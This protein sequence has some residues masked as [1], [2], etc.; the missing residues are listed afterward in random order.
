[1]TY[2]SGNQRLSED[3]IIDVLTRLPVKSLVRFRCVCKNWYSLTINSSFIT[4]HLH[5]SRN[6]AHLLVYHFNDSAEKYVLTLFLDETLASFSHL[7]YDL[8]G[9]PCF[10]EPSI[11]GTFNGILGLWNHDRI[12]LWNPAT[13]VFRSL[14]MPNPNLPSYFNVYHSYFGF[15]LDLETNDYKV[16]S[17]RKYW[18]DKNDDPYDPNVVSVYN[19]CTNSWR[20]FQD[21]SPS[22]FV[23]DSILSNTYMNGLYYWLTL[24]ESDQFYAVVSFDM[25]NEVFRYISGPPNLSRMEYGIRVMYFDSIALIYFETHKVEKHF[26][27]WVMEEEGCWTKQLSIGPLLDVEA[28]FG[29]WKN[30]ELFLRISTEELV[31]YDPNTREIKN[32]QYRCNSSLQAFM[33]M[34]SLVSV[35]GENKLLAPKLGSHL[36]DDVDQ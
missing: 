15:G 18:N 19:L 21:S 9:L 2:K 29:I 28:S 22:R 20:L 8:D 31:L 6:S 33:Y 14:L 11:L 25:G 17:I 16:V 27:S 13:R 5:H 35:R 36:S 7:H 34:E 4:K 30:G 24:D 12:T 26:D 1:M 10:S 23:H 3:L 32:L